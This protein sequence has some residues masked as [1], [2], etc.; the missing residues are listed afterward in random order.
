MLPFKTCAIYVHTYFIRH[1]AAEY[2]AQ[3]PYGNL[4]RLSPLRESLACETTSSALTAEARQPTASIESISPPRARP[5]LWHTC[6][7]ALL[8]DYGI[9]YVC[10]CIYIQWWSLNTID[11]FDGVHLCEGKWEM[12]IHNVAL[13]IV[14]FAAHIF[15]VVTLRT[16]W[17]VHGNWTQGLWLEQLASPMMTCTNT[18]LMKCYYN[19]WQSKWQMWYLQSVGW[20]MQLVSKTKSEPLI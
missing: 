7:G 20:L 8:R 10:L 2:A 3:K 12:H 13:L 17:H 16:N 4:T 11:V 1:P 14:L 19:N 15:G 5:P 9:I 6:M 18:S